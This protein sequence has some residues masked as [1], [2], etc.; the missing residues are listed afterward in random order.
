MGRFLESP[1]YIGVIMAR[2]RSVGISP[3][4]RD[5][6]KAVGALPTFFLVT[7]IIIIRAA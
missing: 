7:I 6:L 1:L 3:V 5:A 4:F 2:L